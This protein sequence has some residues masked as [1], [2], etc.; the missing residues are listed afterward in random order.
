MRYALVDNSTLTAVQ[1]ILGEIPIINKHLIDA[2]IL[3]LENYIQAILFYDHLIFIDDYKESFRHSRRSYFKK[4]SAFSP[5]P[6]EYKSL[7][8]QA[9]LVTEEIVPRVQAGQLKDGD[10]APFFD[11][12]RMNVAFTW[13]RQSSEYFLNVKMLEDVGGVDL[14][15]FSKLACMIY[16]ELD[17]NRRVDEQ[18]PDPEVVLYDSR[19]ELI[20]LEKQSDRV[21]SDQVKRFLSGLNWLAFRTSLYTITAKELGVDL[22]LHPIRHAFQVNL[23]SKLTEG[24]TSIFR[25]IISTM[26]AEAAVTVNRV[27]ETTQPFIVRQPLP[28][29]TVWLAKKTRDTRRFIDAAYELRAERPFVQA[30]RQLIELEELLA[31]QQ[32]SNFVQSANK[33]LQG[34]KSQMKEV[35]S[36][37]EV[38]TSQGL[39][40]TALISVWNLSTLYT[41]WPK[42]PRVDLDIKPLKFLR[43][44]RP[45]KGFKAVYRALVMELAQVARLGEYHDIISSNV[46]VSESAD[47]FDSKVTNTRFAPFKW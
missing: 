13:D 3:A 42:L 20:S 15:K 14:P 9:K 37:Y 46:R 38:E 23:L 41:Q 4:M 7:R 31:Q 21:M 25:N 45:Q 43:N 33:L 32:V 18:Q 22:F 28:M 5:K 30:R 39:P 11:M 6:E 27:L 10:F 8:G 29:F 16:A 12:L 24:E 2:D 17:E 35:R 44:L 36:E 34:V 19:G 47:Y 40:L 1:R 26:N